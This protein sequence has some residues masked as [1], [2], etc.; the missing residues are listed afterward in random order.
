MMNNFLDSHSFPDVTLKKT[1][2]THLN[3]LDSEN[4][5]N[6]EL[7]FTFLFLATLVS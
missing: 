1:Q 3:K 6:R 4:K 2:T 5:I 7:S